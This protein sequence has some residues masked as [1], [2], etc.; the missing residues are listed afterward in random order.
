MGMQQVLQ[1]FYKKLQNLQI[2]KNTAPF[3][4]KI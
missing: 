2:H 1:N 4:I 3:V